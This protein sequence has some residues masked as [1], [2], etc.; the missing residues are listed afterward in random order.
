M[1]HMSQCYHSV[2]I[3]CAFIISL[4]LPEVLCSPDLDNLLITSGAVGSLTLKMY[5]LESWAGIL[6]LPNVLARL[7][8]KE[9]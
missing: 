3:W 4:E 7:H 9:K 5:P 1:H 8:I 2:I 6:V